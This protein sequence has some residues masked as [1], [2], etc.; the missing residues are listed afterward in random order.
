MG[1]ATTAMEKGAALGGQ[2]S[3]VW[4][5]HPLPQAPEECEPSVVNRHRP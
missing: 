5:Q 3:A 4:R 1:K 2:A